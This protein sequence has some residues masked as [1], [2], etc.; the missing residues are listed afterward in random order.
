MVEEFKSGEITDE[1][2]GVIESDLRLQKRLNKIVAKASDSPSSPLPKVAGS[3]AD[4][5][6]AYRF[7]ANDKIHWNQIQDQ[8][9]QRTF[10]RISESAAPFFVASNDTT[11]LNY[12]SHGK[13]NGLGLISSVKSMHDPSRRHRAK[14]LHVH[15]TMAYTADG[16]P[17]GLLSQKIWSRKAKTSSSERARESQKWLEAI[18]SIRV[19]KEF[20]GQEIVY[21]ADRESDI[22]EAY[23]RALESGVS[24]VVRA[25]QTRVVQGGSKQKLFDAVLNEPVIFE[26]DLETLVRDQL[27]GRD[28]WHGHKRDRHKKRVAHLEV[29]VLRA[30]LAGYGRSGAKKKI[31][32]D[33]PV[34]AVVVTEKGRNSKKPFEQDISWM[35]LTD[36][37]VN[38]ADEAKQIIR[39]YSLRWEIETYH[40]IIKSG[41]H[42]EDCKLGEAERLERFI[43]VMGVVAW[44]LAMLTKVARAA[45]E[46]E[47]S[48]GYLDQAEWE[49]LFLKLHKDKPLPLPENPPTLKEA[50][51]WIARLGGYLARK[52]DR[53]P[54]PLVLWRGLQELELLAEGYRIAKRYG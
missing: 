16:V 19:A 46:D 4:T 15:T 7:F 48:Q 9:K 47:S 30:K 40:K 17:L 44:R 23:A 45:S 42:V 24:F 34:T 33:H 41:C 18:E 14:G 43:A 37:I 10:R 51:I 2:V 39:M 27:Q 3:W 36:W 12:T 31:F 26:Y 35:L 6:G 20:S 5:K 25:K 13:T 22:D 29:R 8:H 53:P 28:S 11:S 38:T 52:H 54:G 21:V 32:D 50:I 1:F 49:V